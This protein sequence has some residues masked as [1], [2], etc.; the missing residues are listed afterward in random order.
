[1]IRSSPKT[2]KRR[3]SIIEL[4][5]AA[6][7]SVFERD[8]Y[9]CVRCGKRPPAVRLQPCHVI[10][11]RHLCT[12]WEPDNIFTGCG[13]CHIWWHEYPTLSGDWFRKNWPERHEHIL[14]LYNA[15]AKFTDAR[16]KEMAKEVT[17]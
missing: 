7:E 2:R 12:R 6:R 15:G 14:A 17:R 8:G 10:G 9:A 1:M 4:D 13:G 16:I 11:R 3:R 5:K